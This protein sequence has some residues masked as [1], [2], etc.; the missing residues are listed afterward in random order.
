MYPN[1]V[2]QHSQET[3][4]VLK[5]EGVAASQAREYSTARIFGSPNGD[6]GTGIMGTVSRSE[7]EN[8]AY[9]ADRYIQNMSGMYRSGKIWGVPMKGLFES[10][11]QKT[12]M[13][14]MS[15]SSNTWGPLSL[16]HV[17]EF[18]TLALAVREK[19]GN[20]PKIWFSDLRNGTKP[21]AVS[22]VAAI[23][24]E[25][26]TTMWNPK[27]IRGLQREGSGA[28]AALVEP[29]RNMQ[30]WN[31]IQP[32]TID[33]SLWDETYK[34]YI[35]DKH[36]L[37]MKEYFEKKNPYALQDLTAV[38]LETIRKGMW[39]PS[40]DVIKNLADLHIEMIEKHGA[41]CSI[42]TCSN[43]KLH[44]FLGQHASTPVSLD[45]YRAALNQVLQSR[46]PAPEVEGMQLEE[47]K[48]TLQPEKPI[49]TSAPFFISMIVL[50]LSIVFVS[51]FVR[52]GK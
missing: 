1:F 36:Q 52:W 51:G 38:M 33:S 7:T 43:A 3:E 8:A 15:R 37:D 26:R 12:D 14:I 44:E 4:L 6:Y 48:I 47:T 30:G 29:I 34:V 16:D 35:E 18:N 11:I 17:Y 20:D 9:V 32:D 28:A 10:Q 21:R 49:F 23:R 27:F 50:T 5:K 40:E 39:R 2:K 45:A 13:M 42:D 24:E 41:G 25:A 19:T 46:T 22:A 31:F